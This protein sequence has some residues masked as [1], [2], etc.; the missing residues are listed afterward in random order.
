LKRLGSSLEAS[1]W[2]KVRFRLRQTVI[3]LTEIEIA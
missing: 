1:F 2:C 3:N